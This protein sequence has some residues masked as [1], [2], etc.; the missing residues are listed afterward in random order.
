M[1]SPYGGTKRTN[2]EINKIWEEV[3]EMSKGS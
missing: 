2:K 3:R 1:R